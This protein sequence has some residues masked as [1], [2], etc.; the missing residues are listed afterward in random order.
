MLK[1]NL[2]KLSHVLLEV[3]NSLVLISYCLQILSGSLLLVL[4]N[5]LLKSIDPCFILLLQGLPLVL[6]LLDEKLALA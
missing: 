2:L 4:L 5:R 6:E 3:S 1:V